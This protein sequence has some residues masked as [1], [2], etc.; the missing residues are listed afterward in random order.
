MARVATYEVYVDED[1][2]QEFRDFCT[3]LGDSIEI[4]WK[5]TEDL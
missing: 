5:D 2:E 4:S 3:S 1:K